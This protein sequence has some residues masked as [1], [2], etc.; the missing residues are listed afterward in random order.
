MSRESFKI[1]NFLF[2]EIF[3]SVVCKLWIMD[4]L[5]TVEHW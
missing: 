1:H 4:L 5:N 2:P 3:F